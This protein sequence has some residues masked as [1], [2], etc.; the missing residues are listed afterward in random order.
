MIDVRVEMTENDDDVDICGG[1]SHGG[2]HSAAHSRSM[3]VA[4]D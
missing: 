4:F 1:S 3:I 2:V